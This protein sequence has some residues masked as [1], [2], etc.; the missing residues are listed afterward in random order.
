MRTLG[1][2]LRGKLA[3]CIP[4]ISKLREPQ[5]CRTYLVDVLALELRKKLAETLL[6]SV[7]ADGAQN[8]L[9]VCGGWG[10]VAG[11]AEEEVCC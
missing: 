7:D 1:D 9:D 5:F 2:Q 8:T 4:R 10:G 11:Q 6:V 3:V